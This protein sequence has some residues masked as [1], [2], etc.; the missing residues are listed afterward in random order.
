[1]RPDVSVLIVSYNQADSIMATL[2]GVTAQVADLRI[3]VVVADDASTDGTCERIRAWAA[4]SALEGRFL[5]AERRL[6]IN[7]NYTRGFAACRGKYVAVLEGDDLW[8]HPERLA[9]LASFL[10]RHPECPMVFNRLLVVDEIGRRSWT[11]PPVA[12][13]QSEAYFAGDD[14]A[15][16]NFICNFSACMYRNESLHRLPWSEFATA[17]AFDWLVNLALAKL[18]P[19][20]MVPQ[21][22]SVYRVHAGGAWSGLGSRQQALRTLDAINDCRRVMDETLASSF[23]HFRRRL[24][25]HLRDLADEPTTAV[26]PAPAQGAPCC[27]SRKRPLISVLMASYQHEGY[28]QEAVESVLTQQIDDL[29]LIVVDDGSEDG[30]AE[31]VAAFRDRRVRLLRLARR[32]GVAGALNLALQQVRGEYVAVVDSN[33]AWEAGKLERQLDVLEEHRDIAAVFTGARLVHADGPDLPAGENPALPGISRQPNRSPG[34]WL[35]QFFEI[36]N[37]LCHTSILARREIYDR[38]GYYDNRLRQLP[39]F[40]MSVRL[41][42]TARIHVL[43][44]EDLVR[45]RRVGAAGDT[46]GHAA[47]GTA[48]LLH[49]LLWIGRTFFD[50]VTTEDLRDGFGD[51]MRNPEARSPEELDCEKALLLLAAPSRFSALYQLLGIEKLRDLLGRPPS[52]RLVDEYGLTELAL[53]EL[54]ASS[55]I[56]YEGFDP[57]A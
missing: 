44:D 46:S 18:G 51:L 41:C 45:R 22:M 36:G 34:R 25:A 23:E 1:M 13:N 32:Q 39:D 6:G 28:V 24:E 35:R 50:G 4:S 17:T 53:H 14:L 52:H 49:E 16:D 9:L 7:A 15:R 33:D 8:I 26:V 5:G 27:L 19:I 47:H 48:R 40:E 30:T 57:F 20:G 38:L 10:D 2:E 29:E 54:A 12:F 56:L 43:G 37:C 55:T 31:R 21:V 42:K 11:Q 3:E